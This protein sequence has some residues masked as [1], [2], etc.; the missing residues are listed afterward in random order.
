MANPEDTHGDGHSVASL[1]LV[2]APGFCFARPLQAQVLCICTMIWGARATPV[3]ADAIPCAILFLYF[4]KGITQP[5]AMRI[6]PRAHC[7]FWV[8]SLQPSCTFVTLFSDGSTQYRANIEPTV[9]NPF[10]Y[11]SSSFFS[12]GRTNDRHD[13]RQADMKKLKTERG[14]TTNTRA[15][16]SSDW[17][18]KGGHLQWAYPP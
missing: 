8:F 15:T 9:R 16:K 6:P 17:Q 2:K 3:V 1:S 11:I 13:Q 5:C 10:R 14:G 4:A 18:P 7:L 12:R